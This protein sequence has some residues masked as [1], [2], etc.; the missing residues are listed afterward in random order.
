[1]ASKPVSV[2]QE[3]VFQSDREADMALRRWTEVRA[4]FDI[5]LGKLFEIPVINSTREK[6]A[7]PISSRARSD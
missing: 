7:A 1:M 2:S 5:V 3:L 4:R 6:C